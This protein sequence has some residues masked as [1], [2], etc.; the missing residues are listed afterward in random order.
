MSRQHPSF[1]RCLPLLSLTALLMTGAAAA[2]PFEAGLRI[3]EQAGSKELGMPVYPG[4]QAQR[5]DKADKAAVHLKL[6]GG[7][8]GAHMAVAKFRSTDRAEEVLSFYREVLAPFG[9]VLECRGPAPKQEAKKTEQ[10]DA[11]LRCEDTQDGVVLKVGT[12]RNQRHV[13][14]QAKGQEV[15]FQL[16]RIELKGD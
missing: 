15:W 3:G 7:A 11:P 2:S 13:A 8:F 14:I 5:D 10:R 9:K 1:R 16:V 6:W 12:E 4:A